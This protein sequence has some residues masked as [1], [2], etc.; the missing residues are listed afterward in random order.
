MTIF[1]QK[2]STF[3]NNSPLFCERHKKIRLGVEC[4]RSLMRTESVELPRYRKT[5][6]VVEKQFDATNIKILAA[7]WRHGPRNLLE[8]SRRTQIPFTTVYHRVRKVEG[9]GKPLACLVPRTSLLGMQRI[10]VLV[11]A[12]AGAEEVVTTALKI[13]GLWRRINVCEG[14]FTHLSIHTVPISFLKDHRKY[15]QRLS[16]LRLITRCTILPTG[17]YVPN[18]PNFKYYDSR[19]KSWM[20]PWETWLKSL[21]KTKPEECLEDPERYA[22]LADRKDIL[23]IRELEGNARKTFA[24]LTPLLEMTLQGVKY[25]YD[26]RLGPSGLLGPI[27]Y[28][29]YPYPAEISAYYEI[30]LEFPNKS[31]VD[32][33][34]SLRYEMFFVH[35][36]AKIL[37]RNAILA[38]TYIAQ[39]QLTNMFSFFSDMAKAGLL[40]SYFPIRMIFTGRQTQT[41]PYELFDNEKGWVFSLP[42]CLAKLSKL[43]STSKGSSRQKR[44]RS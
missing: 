26:R 5:I 18:F 6:S 19:S 34:Y 8:I 3:F 27:G 31:A 44:R 37:R 7:M 39:S 4:P 40:V 42:A 21:K 22:L 11:S 24:E 13:P 25:R 36:M 15:L 38:R 2:L 14:T 30:M 17:D 16:A 33:F 23:M 9:K 43:V 1:G 29:I 12:S 10:V 32:K 41:I 20:F 35:G 28:D